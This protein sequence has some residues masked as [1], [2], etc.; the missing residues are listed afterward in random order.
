MAKTKVVA[1]IN[2]EIHISLTTEEANA[3]NALTLYG[4]DD[5][6]KMFYQHLGSSYLKPHEVGLKSLFETAR[7]SI[8]ILINKL[9]SAED[10]LL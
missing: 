2:A 6:L 8:P 5:F 9:Q 4:T 3:L 1:T 10:C 7:S